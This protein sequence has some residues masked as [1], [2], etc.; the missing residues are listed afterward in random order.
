MPRRD[1]RRDLRA[2][3]GIALVGV[4]MLL[5]I[6][7]AAT[8]AMWVSGQTETLIAVN[9]Q[10]AGRANAAAEGGASHAADV[11]LDFLRRWRINGFATP[12][13]AVTSLLLGPDGLAG[14]ESTDLDNGSLESLGLAAPTT[15]MALPGGAASY[16]VRVMDEDDP[17]RG[18]TLGSADIA[19]IGEDGQPAADAN[20]RLLIQAT[21]DAT[22]TRTVLELAIGPVPAPAVVSNGD[23]TIEGN[24]TIQGAGGHVHANGLLHV[25]GST[26]IDGNATASNGLT[27]SGI[28]DIG[29]VA[30]GAALPVPVIAV[31]AADYRYLAD[32][33]LT[34]GGQITAPGGGVICDA[35]G[36]AGACEDAGY[37]WH[38]D[39]AAG[40]SATTLGPSADGRTFYAE[41]P[42]T[43]SGD[44]GSAADPWNVT[45][46]AEGSIDFTGNSTIEANA[47][48]LLFVTDG[49]L[50]MAGATD[51]VGA[52][53]QSL[54]HEQALVTGNS[55]LLGELVIEEAADVSA[56]VA[57][58]NS[59]VGV[60]GAAAITS[61]GTL[62]GTAFA[63]SAWREQP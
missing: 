57:A 19:R 33:I 23:L 51:Q 50:R 8:S 38:Y 32:L 30:N 20:T 43:V 59:G 17:A 18:I 26:V 41:A 15:P 54:V 13:A 45:L 42:L 3:D 55:S 34:A 61:T 5:L 21:G 4:L 16:R 39:G 10:M 12:S 48:G 58:G 25:G 22:G 40:W 52:E 29:G 63:V 7:S 31:N 47:P 36:D 1:T 53:A 62:A 46:V 49:D 24:A 9:R 27:Q 60:T 6:V 14:T 44:L 11:T 2:E 37:T 56:L 35:A 28:P